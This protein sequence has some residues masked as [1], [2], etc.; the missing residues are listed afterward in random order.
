MIPCFT[1]YEEGGVI[2][3]EINIFYIYGIHF[4]P[5]K[6]SQL[7]SFEQNGKGVIFNT[8]NTLLKT[9]LQINETI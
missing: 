6:L 4:N 1:S 7:R 9:Y 3:P 2:L 5:Q 8:S